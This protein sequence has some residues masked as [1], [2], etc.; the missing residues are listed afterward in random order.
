MFTLVQNPGAPDRRMHVLY[1]L[2]SPVSPRPV[3]TLIEYFIDIGRA[4]SLSWQR[5]TARAVGLLVD[6]LTAN[7]PKLRGE[8][9][10][11]SSPNSRRPWLGA[12]SIWTATI[13]PNCFGSPRP[14]RAPGISFER[15]Q[16]SRTGWKIA[17]GRAGSILGAMHRSASRSPSG[18]VS[19]SATPIRCLATR[20][21]VPT[22]RPVPRSVASSP[23]NGRRRQRSRVK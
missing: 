17:M 22:I 13:H 9:N 21:I 6:F 5:E 10:P 12:R 16:H 19:T 23:F 3:V 8:N 20:A 15:S 18:D 7:A 1:L 11:K 2:Q 14:S 4:R